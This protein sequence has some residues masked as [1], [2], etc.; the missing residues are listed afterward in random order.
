MRRLLQS[1]LKAAKYPGETRREFSMHKPILTAVLV[2]AGALFASAAEAKVPFFNAACPGR[3]SVHADEGGPVFINGR[4]AR[5]KRFNNNYYEARLGRLT[6]SVSVN[7]DGSPDVSYTGPGG[8]NGVCRVKGDRAAQMQ[9]EDG[10]GYG[11]S[12][13]RRRSD[14]VALGMM[15][16]YCRGEVSAQFRVRPSRITTNRPFMSGRG[17][18][19][20]GNYPDGKG[21]AFFN[22][23]FDKGGNF[24]SIN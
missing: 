5:L 11:E 9:D 18:V 23:W 22:C 10:G 4:E 20:Q 24:V 12:R 3:V 15:P 13:P 2:A 16:A 6:I 14:G 21:T 8:A 17:Y 1:V 19:V 7:R